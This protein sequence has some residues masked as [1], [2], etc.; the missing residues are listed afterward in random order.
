MNYPQYSIV[1][2]AYFYPFYFLK[3]LL[4]FFFQTAAQVN[5]ELKKKKD[6][7]NEKKINLQPLMVFVGQIRKLESV[8]IVIDEFR[9][10]LATPI[11][12]LYTTFKLFYAVLMCITRKKLTQFGWY[13]RNLR[14][15]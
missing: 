14:M 3:V 4:N 9:Y 6:L 10:K 2:F 13:S 1:F 11:E 12:A 5:S 15:G 8:Y 7:F